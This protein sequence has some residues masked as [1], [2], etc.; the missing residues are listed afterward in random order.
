VLAL[1]N[2]MPNSYPCLLAASWAARRCA[3]ILH[4]QVFMN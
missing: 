4:E 3:K 2:Q 1:A